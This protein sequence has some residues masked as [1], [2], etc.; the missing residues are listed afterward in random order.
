MQGG[1]RA[2]HHATIGTGRTVPGTVWTGKADTAKV[3]VR[4]QYMV[5][6]LPMRSLSR[7]PDS[8]SVPTSDTDNDSADE[9][10][11][12]NLDDGTG[13]QMIEYLMHICGADTRKIERQP[14]R[15][16]KPIYACTH[17]GCVKRYLTEGKLRRHEQSGN[18]VI[19]PYKQS[20]LDV[21]VRMYSANLEASSM[22]VD[23][24][25][26]SCHF[27]H[28][29]GPHRTIFCNGQSSI[30]PSQTPHQSTVVA[31]L[32]GSH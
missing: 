3:V 16:A 12:E 29:F 11:D 8:P 30:V 26:V 22:F 7:Q 10:D 19:K 31:C 20:M 15:P 6:H 28:R 24:D 5:P 14:Q 1:I 21:A 18:H 32:K 2:W 4:T 25:T 13:E 9:T 23:F 27:S 17:D